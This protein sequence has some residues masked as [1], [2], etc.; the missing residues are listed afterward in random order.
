MLCKAGGVCTVS[1]CC[2]RAPGWAGN[3]RVRLGLGLG[4]FIKGTLVLPRIGLGLRLLNREL[5]PLNDASSI[6]VVVG[7][8]SAI[9]CSSVGEDSTA[10]ALSRTVGTA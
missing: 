10:A 1:F 2:A 7:A 4:K 3:G 5:R 6:T 9:S 8:T